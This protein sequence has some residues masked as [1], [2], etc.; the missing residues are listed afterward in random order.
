MNEEE[1]K[2]TSIVAKLGAILIFVVFLCCLPK[3]LGEAN[4]KASKLLY[5]TQID[6]QLVVQDKTKAVPNGGRNTHN[7]FEVEY[8]E[9]KHYVKCLDSEYYKSIKIGD[10]INVKIY[11]NKD[12]DTILLKNN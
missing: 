3:L 9:Q 12:E 6:T 5:P 7:C 11:S 4:N 8:N 10:K 1:N 2:S